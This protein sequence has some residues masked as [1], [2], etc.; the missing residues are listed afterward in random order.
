MVIGSS[1]ETIAARFLNTLV[2]AVPAALPAAL[3]SGSAFAIS[4]LRG[5]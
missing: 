3:S 1:P 2:C 4:R 5:K